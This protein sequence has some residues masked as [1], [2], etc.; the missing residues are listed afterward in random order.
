MRVKLIL[1]AKNEKSLIG[2]SASMPKYF[3]IFTTIGV[4]ENNGLDN[5][6]RPRGRLST[7]SNKKSRQKECRPLCQSAMRFYQNKAFSLTCVKENANDKRFC[8][9]R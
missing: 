7:K 9:N 5:N 1:L 3:C 6:V 8:K 4:R 2:I